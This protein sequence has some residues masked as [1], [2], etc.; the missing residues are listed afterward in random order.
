MFSWDRLPAC[1]NLLVDRLEV[2]PTFEPQRWQ[3]IALQTRY[4]NRQQ[5]QIED[6]K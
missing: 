5:L 1:R 4:N 3:V 2:Y 6:E